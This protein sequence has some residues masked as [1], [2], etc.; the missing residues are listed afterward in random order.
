MPAPAKPPLRAVLYGRVSKQGPSVDDQLRELHARAK[1]Q[2]WELKFRDF[3]D[4]G[5]SASPY[6]KG[7]PR[8]D[9]QAVM[10]LITS[11]AVEV[12]VVWEISR[13][14]RDRAV[15]AALIAACIERQV[16][17]DV[18][19]RMHDPT[20]PDDAF[21]LD[22]GAIKGFHESA[23]ISKRVNRSV[24]GRVS[25]G[26]PH[27][28][29]HYGYRREYDPHT[30]A[31][32]RQV[33][34]EAQAQVMREIAR[35]L[36]AGE[37]LYM[38]AA[39]LNR[40]GVPSPGAV[41]NARHGRTAAPPWTPL[42]VRTR[43]L[44]PTLAGLLVHR[45]VVVGEGGWPAVITVTEHRA[46]VAL[47][48]DPARSTWRAGGS[49][50]LLPGIATCGVCGGAI[51][52]FKNNGLPAYNCGVNFCVSRRQDWVD[53][54]V[55][56]T[57]LAR[58]E[59]PDIAELLAETRDDPEADEAATEL[60]EL[61]ARL[62]G[63][64]ESAANPH[65]ISAASLAAIEARLIP[66]IVDAERRATV[67]RLPPIVADQVGSRARA[68]WAELSMPQRRQ[69]VRALVDVRIHRSDKPGSRY[70]DPSKVEII[71]K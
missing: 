13:T 20:D 34:D 57:V 17:I 12:L 68:G 71:W 70:F 51:R 53:A 54:F 7:K 24:R 52:R 65:G 9:W 6:A 66:A 29:L 31:L 32:L 15:W 27:G 23:T 26:R 33:P 35:R 40:R 58:L 61:R 41:R 55:E 30:G 16:S 4:D 11:G 39:G 10:E 14:T 49:R 46:L 19:G 37:T 44:S 25:A 2:D 60:E 1:Q 42:D 8:P 28:K 69:L 62:A 59:R 38:V 67:L 5:I 3:R 48:T 43:A 45:K 18:S 64:V 56:E 63:F 50:H 21:M 47:L 36:L 22:F